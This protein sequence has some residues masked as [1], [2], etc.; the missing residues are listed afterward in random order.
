[1]QNQYST[2]PQLINLTPHDI[3]VRMPQGTPAVRWGRAVTPI[4]YADIVVPPTRPSARVAATY[5]LSGDIPQEAQ[6]C[7]VDHDDPQEYY[8][9]IVGVP[10]VRQTFGDVEGLPEPLHGTIY[11]VSGLVRS[12][13]G[14]SRPDVVAPD[15]GPTAI[16]DEAGRIRAP[17]DAQRRLA[18]PLAEA[19]SDGWEECRFYYERAL[20]GML[21][22]EQFDMAVKLLHERGWTRAGR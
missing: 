14:S 5:T 11:I 19:V 13:L 18:V 10:I 21:S 12:A 16:R 1:M 9:V 2:S 3:V 6:A 17:I 22:P 4:A 20:K 15:T 7:G 8:A